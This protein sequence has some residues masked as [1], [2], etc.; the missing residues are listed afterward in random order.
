MVEYN[1]N[2]KTNKFLFRVKVGNAY[3][4]DYN[5]INILGA[6]HSIRKNNRIYYYKTTKL[7]IAIYDIETHLFR[8]DALGYKRKQFKI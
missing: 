6:I 8:H 1:T 3:K 5:G 4:A 7:P 2:H